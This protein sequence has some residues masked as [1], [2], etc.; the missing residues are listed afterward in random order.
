M[1]KQW[2]QWQT[3]FLGFQNHCRWWLQPWNIKT[4]APW[5]KSYD[6]PRQHIKKQRH[7]FANIGTY[8]QSYGLS[9]SHVRMW[10][11][12]HK[13]SW[14]PKNWC[15]W[16]A[17]LE[18]TLESPLD[19]KEILKEISPEYSLEGLMLTLKLQHFGQLMQ[20]TETFHW[21]KPD[22]WKD[23]RREDGRG[24]G[25]MASPTRWTWVWVSSGNWWWRGKPGLL[26]SMGSQGV[27]HCWAT[28]LKWTELN[29]RSGIRQACLLS[30][31][32]QH[33]A[34]SCSLNTWAISSVQSLSCVR[35]FATSW[36]PLGLIND[37]WSL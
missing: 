25:W 3:L 7:Y 29:W 19:G 32:I 30:T 35:L 9:I 20:K 12:D 34:V 16:T 24:W 27:R 10:E 22:A 13:E 17:V 2:T 8:S 11:L 1:G 18:K 5:K 36:F 4:L 23:W 33:I 21:K 6:Q 26:Q 28:A 37:A 14:A 15:F 31:F